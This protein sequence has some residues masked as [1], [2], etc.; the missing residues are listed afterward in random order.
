MIK[1]QHRLKG[2][3]V[4]QLAFLVFF[5]SMFLDPVFELAYIIFRYSS[6]KSSFFII[7][8]LYSHTFTRFITSYSF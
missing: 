6:L 5:F 4:Y 8:S 3:A 7:F 2:L 1:F